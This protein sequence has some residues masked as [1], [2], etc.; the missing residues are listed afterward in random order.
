[1]KCKMAIECGT[2]SLPGV[3]VQHLTTEM[4]AVVSNNKRLTGAF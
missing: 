2:V 1:M 4:S 3:I